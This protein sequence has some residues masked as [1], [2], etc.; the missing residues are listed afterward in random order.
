MEGEWAKEWEAMKGFF[1]AATGK[2]R[3]DANTLKGLVTTVSTQTAGVSG[4]REAVDKSFLAY[5]KA[6]SD[7]GKA[8]AKTPNALDEHIMKHVNEYGRAVDAFKKAAKNYEPAIE[9]AIQKTKGTRTRRT[10]TTVPAN[11]SG[12]SCS[13]SRRRSN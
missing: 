5:S 13:R 2:S 12:K 9:S 11:C 4:T 8:L 1:E 7:F 10:A 6:V 3:P